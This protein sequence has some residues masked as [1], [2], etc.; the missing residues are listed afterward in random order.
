MKV[1]LMSDQ[2]PLPCIVILR[3]PIQLIA[4]SQMQIAEEV[5]EALS[6]V[7]LN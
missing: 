4:C 5:V 2:E 3:I 1:T 6:D 7:V